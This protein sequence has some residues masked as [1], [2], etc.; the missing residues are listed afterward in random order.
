MATTA[1]VNTAITNGTSANVSS[2]TNNIHSL[3]TTPFSSTANINAGSRTFGTGAHTRTYNAN[4]DIID[5]SIITVTLTSFA[6]ATTT[7]N[8]QIV[9][10]DIDPIGNTFDLTTYDITGA[11]EPDS[12]FTFNFIIIK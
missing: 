9:V 6:L 5:T 7:R 11:K 10:S 1:F 8:L 12:D 4:I 3:P 2:I